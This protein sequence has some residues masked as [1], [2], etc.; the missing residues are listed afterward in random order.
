MND[1]LIDTVSNIVNTYGV[2]II[3]DYKF[4]NILTDSYS[5]AWDRILKEEFKRNIG[6]GSINHI[7]LLAGNKKAMLKYIAQTINSYRGRNKDELKACLISV[8]VATGT[9]S[10]SDFLNF[11]REDSENP[12]QDW[13]LSKYYPPTA[14]NKNSLKVCLTIAWGG[15]CL[16]GSLM[17]YGFYLYDQWWMI[18]VILLMGLL[19]LSYCS[20]VLKISDNNLKFQWSRS[21]REV[22]KSCFVPIV[23]GFFLNVLFSIL[24]CTESIRSWAFVYFNLGFFNIEDL[25]KSPGWFSIITAL[26]LMFCLFSCFAGIYF[27]DWKMH[28]KS[29]EIRNKY[30]G[31]AIM[32]ILILYGLFFAYPA[33]SRI[34]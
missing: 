7:A 34:P 25:V 28:N 13:P 26:I 22:V 11:L 18:F 24:L 32:G 1:K 29:R 4:W 5:F 23:G 10:K 2:G 33:I 14:E 3:S 15:V 19:Q 17:L 30:M 9:C 20:L 12:N 16:I 21:E 31:I 6:N 8:A 27:D